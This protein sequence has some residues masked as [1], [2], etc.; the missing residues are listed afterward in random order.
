MVLIYCWTRR[1]LYLECILLFE[2]LSKFGKETAKSS[3]KEGRTGASESYE[4]LYAHPRRSPQP[5]NQNHLPMS[6]SSLK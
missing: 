1:A 6:E 5:S 4:Q 3:R 2:S